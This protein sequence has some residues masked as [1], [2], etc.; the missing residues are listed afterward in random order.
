MEAHVVGVEA[1]YE[2]VITRIGWNKAGVD[3]RLDFWT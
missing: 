3:V 2:D 1:W